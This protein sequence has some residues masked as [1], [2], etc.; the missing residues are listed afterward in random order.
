MGRII[1][2][3]DVPSASET[4][5]TEN[6]SVNVSTLIVCNRE[7]TE[8]YF[9]LRCIINSNEITPA[10]DKEYLYYDHFIEA[11]GT[12]F[13]NVELDL[14]SATFLLMESTVDLSVNLVE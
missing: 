5:L 4:T 11:N 14:A 3:V 2:Q 10:Q 13:L 7:A 6:I 1:Q 12:I 8:G 9:K